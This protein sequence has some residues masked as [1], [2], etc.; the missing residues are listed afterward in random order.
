MSNR[1]FSF[2]QLY[3]EL[4]I[5]K[6]E[7]AEV[8]ACLLAGVSNFRASHRYTRLYTD[9]ALLELPYVLGFGALEVIRNSSLSLDTRYKVVGYVIKEANPVIEDGIPHGLMAMLSFLAALGLLNVLL[10]RSIMAIMDMI[11]NAMFDDWQPDEARALVD[12]IVA[13]ADM[14]EEERR[15]WLYYLLSHCR[16]PDLGKNLFQFCLDHPAWS[17]DAKSQV[18]RLVLDPHPELNPPAEWRAVKAM[19]AGDEDAYQ[20]AVA[21]IDSDEWPEMVIEAGEDEEDEPDEQDLEQLDLDWL[22]DLDDDLDDDEFESG[23]EGNGIPSFA[24]LSNLLRG[25]DTF[26]LL[27]PYLKREALVGL[28]ALGEDPLV[29][30][31]TYLGRHDYYTDAINEGVAQIIRSH[32]DNLADDA[33]RNLIDRALGIGKVETRKAFYRLGADLFG[34][35]YWRRASNDNANSIRTWAEKQAAG[36]PP[37]LRKSAQAS[38]SK[39]GRNGRAKTE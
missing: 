26:M 13:K 17:A 10:F 15:W 2:K 14:P 24:F 25:M 3:R 35:E 1:I 6:E 12:W 16:R 32:R 37:R 33:I 9:N 20:E 31:E 5:P 22:A 23:L 7:Q 30:C 19:L 18:C 36:K 11:S 28:A 39:G 27:P 4:E 8:K 21:Q 29:L 38:S 34:P